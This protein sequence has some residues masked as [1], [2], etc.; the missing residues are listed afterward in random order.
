MNIDDA[1]ARAQRDA[2]AARNALAAAQAR[3][4]QIDS[5]S[6]VSPTTIDGLPT[7]G[8][9]TAK[10][11]KAGLSQ[12]WKKPRGLAK[13]VGVPKADSRPVWADDGFFDTV[14]KATPASSFI[15][16]AVGLGGL[17]LVEKWLQSVGW[18]GPEDG[19]IVLFI[20]AFGALSALLYG[21]PAAPLG[22]PIMTVRGFAVAVSLIMAV[23]YAAL[24]VAP[25]GLPTELERVLAPALSVAAMLYVNGGVH[26]PAAACAIQYSLLPGSQQGPIFIL[27]PV[28]VGVGWMLLVQLGLAKA[29]QF[30]ARRA[31]VAAEAA[32]A[33]Q[34]ASGTSL[35]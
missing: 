5:L 1:I 24:F 28:L 35:L 30:L 12:L 33:A 4:V 16:T 27:A 23:H 29:V 25:T 3:V 19:Q 31:K 14:H 8:I 18:Y 20:G 6:S 26:P 32:A 7:D 10:N 21:A 22:R 11:S 15:G 9:V 17:T 2:E 34:S 13:L